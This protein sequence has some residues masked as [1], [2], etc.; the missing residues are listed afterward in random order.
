[1]KPTIVQVLI[2]RLAVGAL[3]LTLAIDKYN[4]GW[5]TNSEP[6]R[7]S[8][9]GFQQHAVGWQLTYL[10][11]VAIPYAGVWSKLILIGEGCIALSLLLGLLVRLTSATG[12]FMLINLYAANGSLFS[13]KFFS[14][15]YGALIFGSLWVF[16]LARAGR[17]AGFDALFAATNPKAIWW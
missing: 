11:R 6:L 10:E 13:L 12:I 1:M 4:E 9:T 17:S 8:L 3:F 14:S 7:T 16:L 5:L 15:P 2:L